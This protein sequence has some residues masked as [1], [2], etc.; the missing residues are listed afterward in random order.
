MGS[1][2][3]EKDE[4]KLTTT[5]DYVVGLISYKERKIDEEYYELLSKAI[6]YGMTPK[7]FWDSDIQYFYCYEVAYINK[8][9]NEAYTHG[10]YNHIAFTTTMGAMFTKKGEK[11]P[12]YPSTNIY[13]P[14]NEKRSQKPT[15]E[16]KQV[17]RGETS[18]GFK[19]LFHIKRIIDKKKGVE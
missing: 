12:E 2:V 10:I 17:N 6:E 19:K 16:F 5:I 4:N 7:E 14:L 11:A 18:K 8:S 1:R 15:N 9:Y 13:N 3:E